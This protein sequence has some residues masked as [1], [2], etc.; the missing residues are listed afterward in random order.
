MSEVRFSLRKVRDGEGGGVGGV[1]GS[2]GRPERSRRR[3][4]MK[5][6]HGSKETLHPRKVA[7][8]EAKFR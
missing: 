8:E 3:Q 6:A 4:K 7:K 1:D 5:H 2:S